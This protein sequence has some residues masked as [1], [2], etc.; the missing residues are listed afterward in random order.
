MIRGLDSAFDHVWIKREEWQELTSAARA[1]KG[2]SVRF[3]ERLAR[4]IARFHLTDNTRGEPPMWGN[5]DVRKLEL[6]IVHAGGESFDISGEFLL[7][8]ENSERGYEGKFTGVLE[9]P[10]DGANP[11]RFEMLAIGNHWGEGNYTRGAREGKNPM[12][13]VF[14]IADGSFAPDSVPPQA[15]RSE[16]AYYQAEKW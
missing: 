3:P 12:G 10:A 8:T 15:I 7:Q 9:Q 16:Q 14:E 5:G 13:V 1:A 4:R 2:K 11:T 6:E